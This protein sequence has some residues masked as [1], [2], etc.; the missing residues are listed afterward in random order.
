MKSGILFILAIM[1]T[2]LLQAKS[3][4]LTIRIAEFPVY[5]PEDAPIYL[6]GNFNNWN[7]ADSKYLLKKTAGSYWIKI[8]IWAIEKLEYKFTRGSWATVEKGINGE[9]IANRIWQKSANKWEIKAKIANWRDFV[10]EENEQPHSLT[11]NIIVQENFYL[12]QLDRYRT[13]RIYLPPD[14]DSSKNRYPVLYMH[15]G[16]NLF[17]KSTSY[18]GEWKIDETLEKHYNQHLKNGVIVVGIDNHSAKRLD[19]Y[20]PWTN[21]EYKAGG[22]GDK[23]VE[24]IAETLKPWIDSHYRTKVE[25]EFTGI[26]GSSMG[27]LISLYAGARY[28]QLFSRLGIFSPAFWFS[29]EEMLAYLTKY[30]LLKSSRVY[31]DVGTQEGDNLQQ[32]DA[33]LNDA[34]QMYEFLLKSG[35]DEKNIRLIISEGDG[36]NET[37]WAKRFPAA[38]LWLWQ[39]F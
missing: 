35:L 39:D 16:Q 26:A 19:E 27:G 15:D 5:T 31:I 24:F 34:R 4:K 32:R 30:P 29:R 6:T 3:E 20:S 7:P 9:E 8:D 23:Y 25:A 17:D 13:L 14:Y 1:L 37:A 11:G 22:E 21:A 2:S 18:A 28:P 12:P 38:F 10:S 33:Y 36:H